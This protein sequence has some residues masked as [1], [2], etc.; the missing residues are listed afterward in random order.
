MFKIRFFKDFG[1]F[2]YNLFH[3]PIGRMFGHINPNE[4]RLYITHHVLTTPFGT[5]RFEIWPYFNSGS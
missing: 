3:E 4:L 2:R 5:F 1:W